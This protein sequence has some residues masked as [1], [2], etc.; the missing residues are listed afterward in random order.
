MPNLTNLPRVSRICPSSHGLTAKAVKLTEIGYCEQWLV[1]SNKHGFEASA[2]MV[3][4]RD[5]T[6]FY[7]VRINYNCARAD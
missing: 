5:H 2:V 3:L 1:I 4:G 7:R 6:I